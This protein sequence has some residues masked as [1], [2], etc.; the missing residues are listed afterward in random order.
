LPATHFTSKKRITALHTSHLY[1]EQNTFTNHYTLYPLHYKQLRYWE[2]CSL[3]V[4]WSFA[5]SHSLMRFINRCTWKS[6]QYYII[7][8]M[9]GSFSAR[10]KSLYFIKVNVLA[11]SSLY[12]LLS[13]RISSSSFMYLCIPCYCNACLKFSAFRVGVKTLHNTVQFI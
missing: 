3:D 7:T 9:M 11:L 10:L 8:I 1:P 2:V 5:S 12:S 13:P 6:P 4:L